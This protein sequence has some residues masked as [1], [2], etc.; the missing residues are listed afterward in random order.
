VTGGIDCEIAHSIPGRVRFRVACVTREDAPVDGFHEAVKNLRGV[1]DVRVNT[2]CGAVVIY[3][4]ARL[5]NASKLKQGLLSI[6]F[7]GLSARRDRAARERGADERPSGW[8][9]RLE[10]S[11]WPA[12]ALAT[13][14]LALSVAGAPFFAPAGFG[15]SAYCALPSFHRAF[16]AVHYERRLNVDVLDS[17]AIAVAT[18]QGSLFTTAFM[19]WLIT[20]GDWIRDQTAAKSRRAIG[21]LLDFQSKRAWVRRGGE[22]ISVPVSE[23]AVGETVIVYD[24][25]MIPVDGRVLSGGAAVDQRTITGE[26]MP[27][28][29]RRGDKVF[30]ASVVQEGKVYLRAERAAADSLAAQ[31]V[32]M[33]ESAPIGETRMQNYAEKFADKL[34]APSLGVAGLLYFLS[35]DINRMLS[36][37]IVD[38]GT[39]IRV[40][41]PTAVLAAMSGAIGHGVLIRGGSRME[42]LCDLDS[43]VFD[44]TGTLTLGM[45]QITAVISYNERGFPA[46]KILGVA[47]AAEVRFKHPVA[48]ATVAK[49]REERIP[50]PPRT[51]SKYHVGLGVE[52]QV[53]GYHVHLGSERFLRQHH[54]NIK[55][56]LSNCRHASGNGQSSLILAVNGEMVGQL[57]YQDKIRPESPAVISALKERD[58]RNLVMLTGDNEAAA[59]HVAS[60]LGITELHAE[61]LPGEK[62]EVVR[63]LRRKGRVVAMVG[64]GINDAAALSYADVGIAMKNGADLARESAH[65]VLVQ[66][67][68][69][70]VV[71]AIDIARNAVRLVHQN[72][73]I[74]V[75]MNVVALALALAGGLIRPE[76][77]A[78]ISNG[79]AVVASVNGLRP[80]IS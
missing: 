16:T 35:R 57:V 78:L 46:A 13:G 65:V 61:I 12:L 10:P 2:Y 48:F 67:D 47:A 24:G 23:I 31:I 37:L 71:T 4:D 60:A 53:N 77:T 7:A 33:V 80:L 44:K 52:A 27:I 54:I 42:R 3:Y 70:R 58:V 11:G 79:S 66:D 14:A 59:R 20:L 76:L 17:L 64:D 72:Y 21:S 56:S 74:V 19:T 32:H 75:G 15:L 41:A 45:P 30:A 5:T 6:D 34:V 29:K 39:G 63:E 28:A 1:T 73:S 49:A 8:L 22:K 9:G 25:E 51:S 36:V 68:L 26:A 18:L 43:M 69:S 62:A 40:A 50:V 55:R 38:F